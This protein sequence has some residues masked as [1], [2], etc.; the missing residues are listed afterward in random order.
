[1]Y[2]LVQRRLRVQERACPPSTSRF[3]RRNGTWRND[4]HGLY[5][6]SELPHCTNTVRTF[7]FT[8]SIL[9]SRM[10]SRLAA[11]SISLA[12]LLMRFKTMSTKQYVPVR[13]TP[14]LENDTH[15]Y[16]NKSGSWERFI[17]PH[18]HTHTHVGLPK[19][20]WI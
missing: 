7:V 13:P 4:V 12:P 15:I 9:W 10:C 16:F 19:R 11:M 5:S 20:F 1:M 18:T 6:S 14:S 8:I 2:L 17:I 3:L